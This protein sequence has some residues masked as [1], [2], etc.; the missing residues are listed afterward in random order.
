MSRDICKDRTHSQVR[1]GGDAVAQTF[2]G[3][4][5]PTVTAR[6]IHAAHAEVAAA[7]AALT[8]E[9]HPLAVH[10]AA[11]SVPSDV[12]A[13]TAVGDGAAGRS[14]VAFCMPRP[15]R[16]SVENA[17]SVSADAGQP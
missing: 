3:Q 15:M 8:G 2:A 16:F 4:M 1:S 6:Y 5:P 12:E 11:F 9:P 17:D 7:I 13:L 10:G 14:G